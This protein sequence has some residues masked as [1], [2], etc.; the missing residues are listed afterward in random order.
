MK[1][2]KSG[3]I[4]T[5]SLGPISSKDQQEAKRVKAVIDRKAGLTLQA[6]ALQVAHNRQ[7]ARAI[8]TLWVDMLGLNGRPIR[9]NDD[10]LAKFTRGRKAKQ[11]NSQK[12]K[13]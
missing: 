4:Q 9:L 8:L 2:G 12:A 6:K 1:H 7:H 5:D 11:L 13:K 10:H 3:E